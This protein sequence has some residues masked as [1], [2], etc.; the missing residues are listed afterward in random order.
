MPSLAQTLPSNDIGFL[1]IVASLWGIELTS[2]DA[3][4]AAVELSETL[5]DAELLEE[6]VST[7]PQ[8]G[9]SALEALT[10][11]NGRMPWV[12]FARRFGDVREMGAGKRD[13]ER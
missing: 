4:E 7:L 13:R 3:A 2:S 5:C 10:A 1:R 8:D 11:E 6:V 9:R 12:A